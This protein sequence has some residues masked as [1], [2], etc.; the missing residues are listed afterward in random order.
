[1]R[2]AHFERLDF[3]I[4]F[5]HL[6]IVAIIISHNSDKFLILLDLRAWILMN[7]L[8][9][10]AGNLKIQTTLRQAT[11][12]RPINILG[13][14]HACGG[15]LLTNHLTLH[16]WLLLPLPYDTGVAAIEVSDFGKIVLESIGLRYSDTAMRS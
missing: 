4:Y 7:Y 16:V 11:P 14:A 15:L 2:L 12:W 6:V 1:M 8:S 9:F 5:F 13:G 10:P 3:Y